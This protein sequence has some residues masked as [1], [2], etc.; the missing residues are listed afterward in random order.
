MKRPVWRGAGLGAL[1]V[2]MLVVVVV[3]G[4]AGAAVAVGSVLAFRSNELGELG[5]TTN[6]GTAKPNPTPAVVASAASPPS[7]SV[8]PLTASNVGICRITGINGNGD[9][10][11]EAVFDKYPANQNR[12]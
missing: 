9:I 3:A 7:Y 4:S 11:G 5:P 12:V 2:L 6:L 8:V 10:V 1:C